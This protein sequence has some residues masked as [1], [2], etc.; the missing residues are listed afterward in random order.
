MNASSTPRRPDSHAVRDV[1]SRHHDEERR[2][3][4]RAMLMAPLMTAAHPAFG[5][6]RRHADALRDWFSQSTGW[7][8]HVE[9]DCARLY[10][11]PA[12]L[13]DASRGAPQFDRRRYLLFC[14]ACAA[15]ERADPQ[16]TLRTLGEKL[17]ALAAE[18]EL[19]A[20]GF[21][22]LLDAQ[23]E[24]RELVAVCRFLLGLG[25][26]HRVAGDE[27]AFVARAGDALYDVQRRVL[28]GLLAATRGP[29]TWPADSAPATLDARLRALVDEYTADSEEGRRSAMRHHLARRLLDDPVVY[30]AEFENDPALL[31][32]FQSQ[33][34]PLAAR[35]CEATGLAPE[36]RAEGLALVDEGGE[37]TDAVMPAEGTSAHVT[38]L[39]AEFLA[40]ASQ[41]G[42]CV[43]DTEVANFIRA[44][45]P[46][47]G[48]YWRKAAREPGA[49]AELARD[50]LGRLAMLRLIRHDAG[51]ARGLPALARFSLGDT[52]IIAR[53]APPGAPGTDAPDTQATLF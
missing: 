17:L 39:V 3:A 49:E 26:L 34:G 21:T 16:I 40:G 1:L 4:L 23:H 27:D 8:L 24:R 7:I 52:E 31:A 5:A 38:L 19:T 51:G 28:A 33:R 18:P 41:A 15:L 47:Y 6:V 44:A 25:V 46:E 29:S 30:F 42:R 36:Q 43:T 9:R 14:L 32:Y 11:R 37:L 53:K 45:A 2:D 10:K 50:A 22:F 35:L 12:D 13:G 48:R 20:R